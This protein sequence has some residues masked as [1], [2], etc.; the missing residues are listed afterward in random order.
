MS[1]AKSHSIHYF[2]I[3]PEIEEMRHQLAN[4]ALILEAE[5]MGFEFEIKLPPGVSK[6]IGTYP[7]RNADEV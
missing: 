2:M 4:C 3:D 5:A 6:H 1:E 7:G